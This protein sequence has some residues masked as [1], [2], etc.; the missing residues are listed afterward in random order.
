MIDKPRI[1]LVN[2][3]AIRNFHGLF[4]HCL[5]RNKPPA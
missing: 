5:Q 1:G 2:S 4:L 3:K